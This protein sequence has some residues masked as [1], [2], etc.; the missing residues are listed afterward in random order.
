MVQEHEDKFTA[1]GKK[2]RANTD[3]LE[4][5]TKLH[6]QAAQFRESTIRNQE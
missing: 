3:M 2:T 5:H 6:E 1:G 4:A